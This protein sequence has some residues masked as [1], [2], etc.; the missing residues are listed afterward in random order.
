MFLVGAW[1]ALAEKLPGSTPC[2]R[3][4]FW[5]RTRLSCRIPTPAESAPPVVSLLGA[6]TDWGEDLLAQ[7][8][9]EEEGDAV[10][11]DRRAEGQP[12]FRAAELFP[13]S[14]VESVPESPS[15]SR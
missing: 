7:G 1:F 2:P 5:K 10:A 15:P 4:R 13:P 14:P 3:R 9:I 8:G 11:D 12:E 6:G